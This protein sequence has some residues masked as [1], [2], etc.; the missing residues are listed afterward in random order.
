M[1]YKD[2]EKLVIKKYASAGTYQLSGQEWGSLAVHYTRDKIIIALDLR[3]EDEW[4]SSMSTNSP[5]RVKVML[6]HSGS[7]KL[8]S[9]AVG[10]DKGDITFPCMDAGGLTNVKGKTGSNELLNDIKILT[11][12]RPLMGN[13]S[14]QA[15][16]ILTSLHPF[17]AKWAASTHFQNN[18]T[19][20][21]QSAKQLIGTKVGGRWVTGIGWFLTK[22]PR[23]PCVMV[24]AVDV[25]NTIGSYKL[26]ADDNKNGIDQTQDQLKTTYC[27][28]T[29]KYITPNINEYNLE[30]E[31][32]HDTKIPC[33]FKSQE[34]AMEAT[35][36]HPGYWAVFQDSYAF[37][38]VSSCKTI[39]LQYIGIPPY[40]QVSTDNIPILNGDLN[41]LNQDGFEEY[42]WMWTMENKYTADSLLIPTKEQ[43]DFTMHMY[44]VVPTVLIIP[45]CLCEF[46]VG[47]YQDLL[48]FST[49]YSRIIIMPENKPIS[50]AINTYLERCQS[51]NIYVLPDALKRLDHIKDR[52][53]IASDNPEINE[54]LQ[55]YKIARS[56]C[57][58]SQCKA[59]QELKKIS[60]HQ[61]I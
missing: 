33:I 45:A 4:L 8:E 14:S 50:A 34:M 13:I 30:Y 1:N 48:F 40:W 61:N 7:Q 22:P 51:H 5:N 9:V 18:I 16:Q 53:Y 42:L 6:Y 27:K 15:S 23:S 2:W 10:Q 55:Q 26:V 25:L 17:A 21:L 38:I 56:K 44:A 20:W 37:G 46:H 41:S 24:K 36:S 19:P 47:F 31:Y 43:A 35:Q 54:Y 28:V 29:P 57:H 12:T 52:I 60:L 32:V 59:E 3:F 58:G 39:Y 49:Q 11:F